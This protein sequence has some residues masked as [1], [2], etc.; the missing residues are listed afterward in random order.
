MDI[1]ILYQFILSDE[2]LFSQR[3]RSKQIDQDPL[4]PQKIPGQFHVDIVL[5]TFE[6]IEGI[7]CFI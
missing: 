4:V 3:C 7:L 6:I 5:E 1:L 2:I